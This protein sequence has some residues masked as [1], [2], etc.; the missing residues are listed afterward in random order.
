MY[1]EIETLTIYLNINTITNIH[2]AQLR[3]TLTMKQQKFT[4]NLSGANRQCRFNNMHLARVKRF[5]ESNGHRVTMD[6]KDADYILFHSCGTFDIFKE[7]SLDI[8]NQYVQSEGKTKVID[9]GCL[10][11]IYPELPQE[12]SDLTYTK[13]M[14]D[15]NSIFSLDKKLNEFHGFTCQSIVDTSFSYPQ[16]KTGKILKLGHKI[17]DFFLY[18]MLPKKSHLLKVLQEIHRNDKYFVEISRGCVGNCSY[19]I[20]KRVTGK[21]VT[22]RSIQDIIDEIA[23]FYQKNI[24]LCLTSDDCGAYGIDIKENIFSLI[25]AI[26]DKFP[27]LDIQLCNIY[28][29]WIEKYESEY[30]NLIQNFNITSINVPIQTGSHTVLKLMNR[31]YSINNVIRIIREIRKRSSKILVWTHIIIGFPG[32]TGDDFK[33][34]IKLIK[35]FD[36]CFCYPYSNS[37]EAPSSKLDNHIPALKK[38]LRNFHFRI[39]YYFLIIKRFCFELLYGNP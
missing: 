7:E 30:L 3:K 29:M 37:K 31:K 32:E 24:K 17:K 15:L 11:K 4:V 16:S 22:S 19:C 21:T 33:K 9:I 14:D 2:L 20:E 5:L 10:T 35:E 36:F 26:N 8:Y 34:S 28:P 12:N 6:A 18:K 39:S 13:E 1:Q 25:K 27:G 38:F 23:Q